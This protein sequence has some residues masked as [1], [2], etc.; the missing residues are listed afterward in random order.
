MVCKTLTIR[1][2]IVMTL[3]RFI[4]IMWYS[5]TRSSSAFSVAQ[6]IAAKEAPAG[7]MQERTVNQ[8]EGLV[9]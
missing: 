1:R 4:S 9:G 7:C 2:D 8:S 5:G 6:K 3:M